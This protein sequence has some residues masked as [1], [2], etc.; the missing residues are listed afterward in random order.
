MSEAKRVT[1]ERLR[2][3]NNV[4]W[5]ERDY[6]DDHGFRHSTSDEP[7]AGSEL[8]S[9]EFDRRDLADLLHHV[10]SLDD[11]HSGAA[12]R[13]GE[14]AKQL[15]LTRLCLK[16]QELC[17]VFSSEQPRPFIGTEMAFALL[18]NGNVCHVDSSRI[19]KPVSSDKSSGSLSALKTATTFLELMA[20]YVESW[21]TTRCLVIAAGGTPDDGTREEP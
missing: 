3:W 1:P 14:L 7:E 5:I 6:Y 2:D 8:D 9:S 20:W 21:R 16:M 15:E 10:D 12:R 11:L 17:N 4:A 19:S 13:V 18:H